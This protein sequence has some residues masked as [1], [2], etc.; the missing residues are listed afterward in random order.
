MPTAPQRRSQ[1]SIEGLALKTGIRGRGGGS[2]VRTTSGS[3]ELTSLPRVAG[4]S[5][6]RLTCPSRNQSRARARSD[7][8]SKATGPRC[9][10]T[11]EAV[12]SVRWPLRCK[13]GSAGP[14]AGSRVSRSHLGRHRLA[15]DGSGPTRCPATSVWSLSRTCELPDGNRRFGAL[16]IAGSEPSSGAGV[17]GLIEE[18][19]CLQ[20]LT[21]GW[22][23]RDGSDRNDGRATQREW[24]LG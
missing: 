1:A 14:D 16:A 8:G 22:M 2:L 7:T 10:R 13:I 17:T 4:K 18:A 6:S 11:P 12:T 9:R 5:A 15:T 21:V 20:P 19:G 24:S 23:P 3:P